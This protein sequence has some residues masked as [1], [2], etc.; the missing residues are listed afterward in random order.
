MANNRIQRGGRQFFGAIGIWIG[1]AHDIR[2]EHNEIAE[3]PYTGVSVGW[4]W[5]PTPTPAA[6]NH[7]RQNHIHHVMQVLSDGGGIYTLGRQPGSTLAGNHIH[8]VPVNAGR[9]ESN[10]MFLD[11]GTDQFTI[12]ANLIYRTARSPLRF[13]QARDNAV[14]KNV[15]VLPDTETPPVRYNSTDPNT[16]RQVDNTI[17]EQAA[18][19]QASYQ[20]LIDAADPEP[21]YRAR[22]SDYH[23]SSQTVLGIQGTHFTVNGR[24][25]FLLGASYYGGLGADDDL[26]R[27]DFDDLERHGVNWLRVW[28]T[29]AYD[30]STDLAQARASGAG[31]W[32]FHNGDERSAQDGRP[33]RSFDLREHSLFDQLDVEERRFL[34][35]LV[36]PEQP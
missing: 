23:A 16:I 11:E 34:A 15:L 7:I 18:F 36:E 33:R 25:T 32:C 2:V 27:R 5:N 17:I 21:E 24:P 20:S 30:F 35:G 1:L 13:H 19:D 26:W 31:G 12:S 22:L 4:M 3:L 8:D 28:A 10:G 6:N 9:A 14:E 29:W